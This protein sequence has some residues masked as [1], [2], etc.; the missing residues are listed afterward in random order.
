MILIIKN[1]ALCDTNNYQ[2]LKFL[3]FMIYK[4]KIK[5]VYPNLDILEFYVFLNCNKLII[6]LYIIFLK[7][8]YFNEIINM[9]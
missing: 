1:I 6:I 7:V 8:N 5:I 9:K 3:Y 2:Y 4:Q